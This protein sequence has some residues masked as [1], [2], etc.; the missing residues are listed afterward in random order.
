MAFLGIRVPSEVGRL[1][2]GL[3]VP[4]EKEGLSLKNFPNSKLSCDILYDMTKELSHNKAL[5]K[6]RDIANVLDQDRN[7]LSTEMAEI[8]SA[9]SKT[10]PDTVDDNW[11]N[12]WEMMD[13]IKEHAKNNGRSVIEEDRPHELR[14]AWRCTNTNKTWS[15]RITNFRKTANDRNGG[16]ELLD[17]CL[18]TQEGKDNL[19]KSLNSKE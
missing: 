19:T 7:E 8:I 13:D 18:Q 2:A 15:I 9:L 6:L 10:S 11:D 16:L 4:G 17:R 3:E 5:E 12:V 14:L 1:I